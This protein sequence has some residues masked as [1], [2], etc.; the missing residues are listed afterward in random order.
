MKRKTGIFTVLLSALTILPCLADPA[1]ELTVDENTPSSNNLQ[2]LTV[3]AS[4]PTNTRPVSLLKVDPIKAPTI[5]SNAIR[6]NVEASTSK[7]ACDSN[8]E[9][10]W[11]NGQC[12]CNDDKKTW[13]AKEKK[14]IK[15]ESEGPV[16]PDNE[17]EKEF[18]AD[19]DKLTA[20]FDKV[21][22]KLCT[23]TTEDK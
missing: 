14:C 15:I 2:E 17:K 18:Y 19:V 4:R 1:I 10:H 7:A 16:K 23:T 22:A 3:T 9:A 5:D 11:N 8:T 6:A 21:K 20:S 13:D 12:F